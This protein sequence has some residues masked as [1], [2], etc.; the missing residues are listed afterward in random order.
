MK[1]IIYL[2]GDHAGFS[3]KENMKRFLEEKGIDYQDLGPYKYNEKDDYPDYAFK[4]GEKVAKNKNSR[5]ILI[6]GSGLG[7]SVAA[8]KVKG[9]RAVSAYDEYSARMSRIDGDSNVLGLSGK[10]ISFPK[11]KSIV[12]VWLSTK[13]S[14]AIRHKRRITKISKYENRR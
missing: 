9:I 2:G 3:I 8:N 1:E 7:G 13:F 14:K 5:G 11:I 10:H 4:V 6:C 12:S